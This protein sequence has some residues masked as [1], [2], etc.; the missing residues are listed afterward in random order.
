[1]PKAYKTFEPGETIVSEGERGTYF[2]I[3]LTGSA[4]VFLKDQE[5]AHIVPPQFVGEVGFIFKE[6]HIATVIADKETLAI[7]LDAETFSRL[8]IT[9]REAVKDKIIAGLVLR[10][11]RLN[12][13]IAHI[14]T[15]SSSKVN[16]LEWSP[17]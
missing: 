2:Y 5:L 1:M 7:E 11:A 15:E 13:S 10:L 17:I 3:L 4:M 8:P 14:K 16:H 6:K 9:I 12:E